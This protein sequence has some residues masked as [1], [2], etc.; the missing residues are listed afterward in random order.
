M[1]S[2]DWD[3]G[4]L[5]WN[6]GGADWNPGCRIGSILHSCSSCAV[7]QLRS[8]GGV[9]FMLY[10]WHFPGD[11]DGDAADSEEEYEALCSDGDADVA[12]DGDA[13]VGDAD[14][15]EI[16]EVGAGRAEDIA[17]A[18]ELLEEAVVDGVALGGAAAGAAASPA[19]A[20]GGGE[21]GDAEDGLAAGLESGL[22]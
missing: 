20:A 10:R 5:D 21:E 22:Q 4:R 14:H 18:A 2:L 6:L 17:E 12:E 9:S 13:E 3:S 16:C 1:I 15:V 11:A 7:I 19:D 8:T